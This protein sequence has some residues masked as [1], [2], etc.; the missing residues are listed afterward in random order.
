M[1]IKKTARFLTDFYGSSPAVGAEGILKGWIDDK[2]TEWLSSWAEKVAKKGQDAMNVLTEI[3]SIFHRDDKGR[4]VLGNWMLRRCLVVTGQTIFNAMKDKTHPKRDILPMAVQLVEPISINI[5]NGKIM[6]RPDG[7]KT[8]T[9]SITKPQ[10]SFFKAYEFIKAGTTF[11]TK[12]Y[13]DDELLTEEHINHLL[14]KAGSVGV[15]AFRERF[16][17]FE[18]I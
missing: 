5:M 15:G 18:W 3:L 6:D 12:M 1:E 7:I 16:G 13:F 8:Y 4:P 11:E 14:S 17:K 10:R 2:Q 9:V